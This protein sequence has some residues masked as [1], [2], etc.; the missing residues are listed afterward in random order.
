MSA[1]RN[2]LQIPS[3]HVIVCA[4][5]SGRSIWGMDYLRPLKH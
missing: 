5:D 1:D 2:A 4:D 3:K